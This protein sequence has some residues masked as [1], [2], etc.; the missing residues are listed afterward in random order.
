MSKVMVS[1]DGSAASK[2]AVSWCAAHLPA[3][4]TVV[5]VGGLSFVR[6]FALTVRPL[7]AG[8]GNHMDEVLRHDWCQP[9][10]DAGL[11]V[12]PKLVCDDDTVAL[13]DAV[14]DEKPDAL[15][16]GKERRHTL[17]DLF[18]LSPLH[19]V[20]HRLPCPLIIVPSS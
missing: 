14:A 17:R 18:S 20:V 13:L 15:V 10:T 6:Q 8:S 5:A 16:L 1:V 9:L 11:D 19:R 12:R 7:P 3:D 4:T 2:A